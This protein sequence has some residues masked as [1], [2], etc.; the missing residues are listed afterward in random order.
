MLLG[1]H[2]V[3]SKTIRICDTKY[4]INVVGTYKPYP[5]RFPL[6]LSRFVFIQTW[7]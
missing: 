2:L 6:H 3:S 5:T 7:N 4:H 1:Q